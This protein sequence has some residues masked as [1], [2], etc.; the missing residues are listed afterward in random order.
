MRPLFTPKIPAGFSLLS[1]ELQ[2]FHSELCLSPKSSLAQIIEVAAFPLVVVNLLAFFQS[3][4]TT[5]CL[6]GNGTKTGTT[7]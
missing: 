2:T 6:I 1:T 3:L 7:I 5:S 4:P